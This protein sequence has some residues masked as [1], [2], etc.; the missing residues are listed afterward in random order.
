MIYL[1]DEIVIF[2]EEG[3]SRWKMQAP[4]WEEEKQVWHNIVIRLIHSFIN[5]L[6]ERLE[7]TISDEEQLLNEKEEALKELSKFVFKIKDNAN[8]CG[9]LNEE[10]FCIQDTDE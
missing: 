5:L 8:L 4:K 6:Y 7:K 3:E 2:S 10:I 9:V 1:T